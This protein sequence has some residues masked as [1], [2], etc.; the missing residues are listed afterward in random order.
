MVKVVVTRCVKCNKQPSRIGR[1]RCEKCALNNAKY[2]INARNRRIA[3]GICAACGKAPA[4][5]PFKRC[6]PCLVRISKKTSDGFM[7]RKY[8]IGHEGK[9]A[10][11]KKQ[12]GFCAFCGLPLPQATRKCHIDHDH[13]TGAVRGLLHNDCNLMLGFYEKIGPRFFECVRGYLGE[14]LQ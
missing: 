11:Y 3:A 10:M 14:G 1:T 9:E 4:D 7:K 6:R 2:L 12:G 5:K 8:G 13:T